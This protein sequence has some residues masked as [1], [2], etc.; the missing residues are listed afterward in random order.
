M[1]SKKKDLERKNCGFQ[2][3]EIGQNGPF[4]GFWGL[5]GG[6]SGAFRAQIGHWVHAAFCHFGGLQ[7]TQDQSWQ[8]TKTKKTK[9]HVFFHFF[10]ITKNRDWRSIFFRGRFEGDF[11]GRG[12]MLGTFFRPEIPE[13]D[14]FFVKK[15]SFWTYFSFL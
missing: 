3:P 13:K 2:S 7:L 1:E 5:F 12:D 9:K 10:S 6:P 4:W 8:S 11:S 14:I 15:S